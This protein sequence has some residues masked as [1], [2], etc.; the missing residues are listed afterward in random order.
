MATEDARLN[1]QVTRAQR[2]LRSS[3]VHA[4]NREVV[5][6]SIVT[7]SLRSD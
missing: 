1:G 7:T 4:V 6:L 3:A 5:R 2:F